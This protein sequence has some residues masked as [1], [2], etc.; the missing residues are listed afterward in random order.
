[1]GWQVTLVDRA[2]PGDRGAASF[3][4]GGILARCSIVPVPVPGLLAKAPRML[5]DP[6]EPLYLRWS[7]VPRMAPFLL[8]YLSY[9]R[10]RHVRRIAAALAGLT[11]DS[12]EEHTAL[13]AGTGAER[14]I[15]TGDYGHLFRNRAQYEKD[16]LGNAIRAEHGFVPEEV[17]RAGLLERDPALGEAWTFGAIYPGHGW[18]L[19]PGAYV[20]A[21]AEHFAREGGV[22]RR[23]EVAALDGEGK[24]TLAG[25]ATMRAD[26]VVLAAGAWSARLAAG[27]GLRLPM[28]SERGYHLALKNPAS[29]PAHPW[30][31]SEVKAVTTP[32][33]FGVRLA[34]IVEFGGLEAGPSAAPPRLLRAAAA[35]IWPGLE[36][37]AEEEWM[38]HR[39][40]LADSLPAIGEIPG[41]PAVIAAFG[42]QHVGLTA[43]PRIGRLAAGIAAG[44]ALNEDL[45][46]CAPGRFR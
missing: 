6:N 28:E 7:H 4:N 38:G 14:F 10:E 33:D 15:R 16:A 20:A 30:M 23:A 19:N 31:V 39:P 25:G 13:A 11:G 42:G 22:I 36:W 35:R 18:I 45:S 9:G 27:L 26:R 12:V 17:D 24:V 5:L 8:R 2:P 29:R 1:M 46:A 41:A 34:G 3:G 44:Q 21:L 43:G 37:E 40:V 32:M